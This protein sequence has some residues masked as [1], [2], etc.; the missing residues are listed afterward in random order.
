[1]IHPDSK[2][3]I[4]WDLIIIIF[5]VYNSILIPYQ[6]AYSVQESISLEVIDRLVDTTFI[7]DIAINFK[8][9]YRDS[10]TDEDVRD[11][12]KIALRYLFNG[13]FFVDLIASLPLEVISLLPFASTTDLSFLGM[14][15]LVRLLRLGRMITFLKAN[16]KLKFSMKFAQLI[17]FLVLLLHW[18]NCI[19]Y[20]VT[21]GDKSW[22]PPKDLDFKTTDAYDGTRL[23]K[24]FLY[25]YYAALTL[26][27]SEMLPTT[28]LEL[29][30]FIL[31][32]FASTIVIGVVIGEF[33]ALISGLTKSDREANER[34]DII[35]TVMVNLRLSDDLQQRVTDYYD[36]VNDAKYI[37]D[38]N[39]YVI[40]PLSFL[41]TIQIFPTLK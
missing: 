35:N 26:V 34:L 4:Y 39:F 38:D 36:K 20:A 37:M 17:F 25:Y 40:L 6:L 28:N 24:Y 9:I 32:I 33:A 3:K 11:G 12:R 14:L 8:T 13:R 2:C 18:I 22:F 7:F 21:K 5:S 41:K 15:K 10:Y 31:L 16:Q 1:L 30:I 27:G 29:I 19:L 23:V